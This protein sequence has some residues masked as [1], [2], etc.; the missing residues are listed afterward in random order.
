MTTTILNDINNLVSRELG[1]TGWTLIKER[2]GGATLRTQRGEI[3]FSTLKILVESI[4]ELLWLVKD[5]GDRE[6]N[7]VQGWGDGYR[8]D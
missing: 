1:T 8:E 6:K 2:G 5:I 7:Y 4:P 3:P